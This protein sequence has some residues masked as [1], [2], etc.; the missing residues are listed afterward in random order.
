MA[1]SQACDFFGACGAGGGGGRRYPVLVVMAEPY[2]AESTQ[3]RPSDHLV[4]V[5]L[6]AVRCGLRCAL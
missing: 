3:D 1:Q 2:P 4:V 5:G 6:L